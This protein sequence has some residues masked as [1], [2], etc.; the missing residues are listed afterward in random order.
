[1]CKAQKELKKA[2]KKLTALKSETLNVD[3][4]NRIDGA[5]FLLKCALK[6]WSNNGK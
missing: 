1:V 5:L 4:I 6:A 2:R 3:E